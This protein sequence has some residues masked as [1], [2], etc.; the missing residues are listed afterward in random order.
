MPQKPFSDKPF[1]LIK[2]VGDPHIKFLKFKSQK[3]S[4]AVK[5]AL[6][7]YLT[8]KSTNGRTRLN[9]VFS[10]DGKRVGYKGFMTKLKTLKG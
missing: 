7:D 10:P 9:I 2:S 5:D 4:L 3:V 8:G 6:G 1:S